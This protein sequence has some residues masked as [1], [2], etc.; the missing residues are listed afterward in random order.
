VSP[1]EARRFV[2]GPWEFNT[3]A[4][5]QVAD[6]RTTRPRSYSRPDGKNWD[7]L[8]LTRTRPGHWMGS[9]TPE[10]WR[11]QQAGP[12]RLQITCARGGEQ[13]ILLREVQ[14]PEPPAL[15]Q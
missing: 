7:R 9:M 1:E 2:W 12:V 10:Q 3:G 5:A 15:E 13:W 6:N 11:R 4:S 14:V 8:G